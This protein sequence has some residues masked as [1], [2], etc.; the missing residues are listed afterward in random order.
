MS[1]QAEQR[2][3]FAEKLLHIRRYLVH[4]IG[5][6][7]NWVNLGHGLSD[8]GWGVKVSDILFLAIIMPLKLV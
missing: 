7:R 3:L 5:L 4:N 6:Q 1:N 8:C 2:A